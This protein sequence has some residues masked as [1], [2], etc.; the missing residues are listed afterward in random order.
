MGVGD[1][2]GRCQQAVLGVARDDLGLVGTEAVGV[3]GDAAQP[4]GCREVGVGARVALG[5]EVVGLARRAGQLD[6]R[7]LELSG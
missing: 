4:G 1:Q 2:R 3:A 6:E 5:D 7:D